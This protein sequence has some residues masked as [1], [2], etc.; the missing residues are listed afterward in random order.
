M[1]I[2]WKYV[3][4]PEC[5]LEIPKGAELLSVHEQG[6]DICLW[7]LVDPTA[8]KEVRRFRGFGTGH[9]IPDMTLKFVGTAHLHGGGLVFHVFEQV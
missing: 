5:K 7:V 9:D 6:E 2:I 8:E 3:L 1:K 4:Q